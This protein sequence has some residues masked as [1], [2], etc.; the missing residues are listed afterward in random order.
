MKTK[1]IIGYSLLTLAILFIEVMPKIYTGDKD[2][3]ISIANAST[4]DGIRKNSFGDLVDNPAFKAVIRNG[5]QV[6]L[7]T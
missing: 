5:G 6:A 3:L 1:P 2:A 7:V 4:P